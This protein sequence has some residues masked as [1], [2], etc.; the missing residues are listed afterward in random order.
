MCAIELVKD[1]GTKEPNKE[2]A[3]RFTATALQLGLVTVTAGTYGNVVRTLMPLVITDEQL[4]IGLDICDQ[5]LAEICDAEAGQ[6]K[7]CE[8]ELRELPVG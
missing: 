2:A 6:A 4:E 5:T 1:R 7:V 3:D 8:T